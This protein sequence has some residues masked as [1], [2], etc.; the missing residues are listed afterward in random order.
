MKP[1][2]KADTLK[3]KQSKHAYNY[4]QGLKDEIERLQSEN[5]QLREGQEWVSNQIMLGMKKANERKVLSVYDE[6][7][8]NTIYDRGHVDATNSIFLE[9]I[10][11]DIFNGANRQIIHNYIVNEPLPSPPQDKEL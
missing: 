11:L 10:A 2:N 9:L 6:K 7:D 8:E 5:K 1:L 4:V 3:V